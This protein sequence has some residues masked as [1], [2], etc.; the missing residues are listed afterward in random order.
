MLRNM[1]SPRPL[2]PIVVL[3]GDHAGGLDA[4][5]TTDRGVRSRAGAAVGR[6]RSGGGGSC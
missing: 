3:T 1:S 2:T 4:G 6:R 5:H